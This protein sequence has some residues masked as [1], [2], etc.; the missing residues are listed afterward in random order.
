M[1][2]EQD[3]TQE[4]FEEFLRT[5][6][7]DQGILTY[8]SKIQQISINDETSLAI[9]FMDLTS[10]DNVFTAL[11]KEDPIQFL[12]IADSALRSILR[13][14]DP[15]YMAGLDEG[16]I[17]IRITHYPDHVPLRNLRSRHIGRLIHISG[18]LMRASVVKPLLVQAVFK[19]RRCNEEII[20]PQED[21]RYIEPEQCPVC[22]KKT[23]VRLLPEK[24]E[25]K[26]WQKVRI[27]ESP[28]ELPPGQ[29]PRSVDVIFEGDIVD[30]SRPGDFVKV[31]GILL[32]TPDFSRRGGRL[33]TFNIFIQANGV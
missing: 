13:I 20:Q 4:R 24:S 26:D 12:K 8:W 1:S 27:Q 23:P 10:F 33:A 19:C 22:G 5:Y 15:D 16:T 25:F 7:D 2:I 21:G 32:T 31:T 11:A 6:K 9:N 29:M 30:I 28:D 18:I 3:S 14:E 17:C